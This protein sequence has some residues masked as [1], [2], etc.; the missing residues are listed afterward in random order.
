MPTRFLKFAPCLLIPV[1][2]STAGCVTTDK[3]YYTQKPP[4]KRLQSTVEVESIREYAK[5]LKGHYSE[6][7]NSAMTEQR[8]IDIP[9]I[10]L[11]AGTLASVVYKGS[12]DLTIGL[13]LATGAVGAYRVYVSPQ[14]RIQANLKGLTSTECAIQNFEKLVEL[15]PT[16]EEAIRDK[17]ST[18]GNAVGNTGAATAVTGATTANIGAAPATGGAPAS[19]VAA[20][21]NQ[22]NANATKKIVAGIAAD[23][24][25]DDKQ[26]VS[27]IVDI[28]ENKELVA[29][30]IP[31]GITPSV[32]AAFSVA[33]TAL[34]EAFASAKNAQRIASDASDAVIRAPDTADSVFS[35][36]QSKI[37]QIIVTGTQ[38]LAAARAELLAGAVAAAQ[39]SSNRDA[40]RSGTLNLPQAS[41]DTGQS[42]TIAAQRSG[43]SA[44]DQ[45]TLDAN[46]LQVAQKMARL[47]NQLSDA[48]RNLADRSTRALTIN[49][50]FKACPV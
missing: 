33:Q 34:Q 10:G 15:L 37:L 12:T 16:K 39:L 8:W 21:P 17:V 7:I 32:A 47:S 9:L 38:D 11:A 23:V 1:A 22:D 46:A 43:D 3:I 44:P 42:R 2:L 20:P 13:G 36:I 48:S 30:S 45:A 28:S 24:L 35:A 27:N 25:K 49:E 50:T 19:P 31:T 14:T 26:Q 4:A 29:M 6:Q 5:G 41:P 18:P 40:I